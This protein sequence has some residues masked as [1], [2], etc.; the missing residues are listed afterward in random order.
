MYQGAC[1]LCSIINIKYDIPHDPPV[2]EAC[3]DLLGR[4]LCRAEQ[5]LTVQEI[6]QHPWFRAGVMDVDEIWKYNEQCMRLD[7]HLHANYQTIEE[8]AAV[9]Q[10]ASLPLTSDERLIDSITDNLSPSGSI[11]LQS[12]ISS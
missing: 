11:Q 8:I 5:R 3:K 7:P 2:S 12:R 4:L 10:Q 6:R 1:I 9:L